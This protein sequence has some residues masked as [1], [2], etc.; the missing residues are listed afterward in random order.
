MYIP[1][2]NPRYHNPSLVEDMA[3]GILDES[4]NESLILL[5]GVITARTTQ[6]EINKKNHPRI[7]RKNWDTVINKEGIK[8]ID[9]CKSSMGTDEDNFSH[10][11]K[12]KGASSS[13]DL[14]IRSCKM[15]EN[16]K[17][18]NYTPGKVSSQF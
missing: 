3:I 18:L 9:F 13:V 4:E 12:N 16:V 14:P 10:Y 2:T 11:N 6:E 5:I 8:I 1:P 15:F 17:G 7:H